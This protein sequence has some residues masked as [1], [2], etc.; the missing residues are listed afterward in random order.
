MQACVVHCQNPP[1][2]HKKVLRSAILILF[3]VRNPLQGAATSVERWLR[4]NGIELRNIANVQR[5]ARPFIARHA[6]RNTNLLLLDYGED[7]GQDF[8]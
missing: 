5:A 4:G 6:A 3:G 2:H 1:H 7:N 8:Y